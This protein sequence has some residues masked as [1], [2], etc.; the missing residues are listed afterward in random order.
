MIESRAQRLVR[1]VASGTFS[2][3]VRCISS[4]RTT[5]AWCGPSAWQHHE[6]RSLERVPG[7]CFGAGLLG[8]PQMAAGPGAAY[9]RS[10]L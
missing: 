9:D 1:A 7:F 4:G 3:I 10:S 6:A 8:P 2:A 5:M